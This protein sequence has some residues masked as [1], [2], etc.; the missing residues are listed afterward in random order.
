MKPQKSIKNS[1]SGTGRLINAWASAEEE[2]DPAEGLERMRGLFERFESRP[3]RTAELWPDFQRSLLSEPFLALLTPPDVNRLRDIGELAAR[4]EGTTLPDV[5]LPLA[6]TLRG[7]GAPG[8]APQAVSLFTRLYQSGGLT[9]QA[10]ADV[11]AE[12]AHLGA[13]GEDQLA[14][15]ADLLRTNPQIPQAVYDHL[16]ML[17]AAGF[18]APAD[19]LAKAGVLARALA[20]LPTAVPGGARALGFCELL[21][22]DNAAGAVPYFEAACRADPRD[23]EALR[24][25]IAAHLMAGSP[26]AAV[27]AAE[28]NPRTLGERGAQLADLSRM[29]L[30]LD[31][32]DA[33]AAGTPAPLDAERIAA[34]GEGP[35]TGPWQ[36]YALGRAQL[37]QGRAT[38][39]RDLLV[40][41]A[42]RMPVRA[43]IAYHAAW[44]QLLCGETAPAA[45][46]CRALLGVDW[47]LGGPLVDAD[48]DTPLDEAER[49]SFTDAGEL[50]DV[51]AA[52]LRLAEGRRPPRLPEWEE[53]PTAGATLPQLL[54]TLR[55]LL[56]VAAARRQD[57]VLAR[58]LRLPLFAR[59]PLAEQWL[60]YGLLALPT[61]PDDGRQRLENAYGMGRR[62][63]R[64]ALAGQELAQGDPAKVAALLD[65]LTGRRAELL[66]ARAEIRLGDTAAATERLVPLAAK[67]SPRARYELGLI[68]FLAA[69]VAWAEGR[70]D[71]AVRLA[72]PAAA[73]FTDAVV[74]GVDALPPVPGGARG[75]GQAARLLAERAQ[76]P[77]TGRA[78][79]RPVR[80]RE[81]VGWLLGLAQL[82]AEPAD[83]EPVLAETMVDWALGHPGADGEPAVRALGAALA[84]G[85]AVAP[86]DEVRAEL[87]AQLERLTERRPLP[88]LTRLRGR[89]AHLAGLLAGS[90]EPGAEA[91]SD[92]LLALAAAAP[93]LAR[94]DREGAARL[95]TAPA[96]QGAEAGAPAP[97]AAQAAG[98]T[99]LA[100]AAVGVPA[101]AGVPAAEQL[102]GPGPDGWGDGREARIAR[103]VGHALAGTPDQGDPPDDGIAALTA[104]LLV[105]RAAGLAAKD[106][107][108][109]AS[110]LTEALAGHNLT[111][112]ISL[113]TALPALCARVARAK[114][115]DPRTTA[116][117][118]AIQRVAKAHERADRSDRDS[119]PD[120]DEGAMALTLARC[121]TAVGDHKNAERMWR[122][123]LKAAPAGAAPAAA[124]ATEFAA[125]LCHRATVAYTEDDPEGARLRLRKALRYVPGDHPA[126]Q[127]VADLERDDH[128]DALLTHLL[129][130]SVPGPIERTGRFS[131]LEEALSR[132]TALW[133][134]LV[135]DDPTVTTRRLTEFVTEH[136]LDVPVLHSL[137]V[138]YREDVRSR[139]ARSAGTG[140]D[141]V[142]ATALWTL[143]LASPTFWNAYGDRVGD[144]EERAALRAELTGELLEAHR[145]QG[146]RALVEGDRKGARLHLG[147]LTA[148]RDGISTTRALLKDG[149]FAQAWTD[150]GAHRPTADIIEALEA[151]MNTPGANAELFRPASARAKELIDAWTVEVV[152]SARERVEDPA[153]VAKLPN[154]IDKDYESGI[155]ALEQAVLCGFQPPRL[156]L[157]ILEWHNGWQNC[158]YQMDE[159]DRMRKVVDGA[160]PYAA[161]LAD[162]CE[163]GRGHLRENQMLGQH[164]VDRGFL[165][166]TKDALDYFEEALK[167]DP[168]NSN[169]PSLL[170]RRRESVLFDKVYA[171]NKARRYD[172]ALRALDDVPRSSATEKS[173]DRLRA[174]ILMNK[175]TKELNDFDFK[176]A[177]QHMR[178]ALHLASTGAAAADTQHYA[179]AEEALRSVATGLNNRGVALADKAMDTYGS[180]AR[181][182][183]RLA[184]ELNTALSMLMDAQRIDPGNQTARNNADSV[185]DL[186]RRLGL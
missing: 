163:P 117:A 47:A 25:L 176:A 123:A 7:R 186:M 143:M 87:F 35:D 40:P 15:Y 115:R 110:A 1:L 133:E 86:D 73:R 32:P 88:E 41:L 168:S 175:G 42:E 11:A 17:L 102:G 166:T 169:A 138:L 100:T 63:A 51:A 128:M 132:R 68:G 126:V 12:L 54:E 114:R 84:R 14:L 8:D 180:Y 136:S 46:R 162:Q 157:T 170:D 156:L 83:A 37:L 124:A 104:P 72:E 64:L 31:S 158:L 53:L 95:L 161:L 139:L 171:E 118:A 5:W 98:G 23:G 131:A 4:E 38:E 33:T 13:D 27:T 75:L 71:E 184:T 172:S 167:W 182:S 19:R 154:G 185:R 92:P 178:Q 10:A 145:A 160:V 174:V 9:A 90:R 61:Y 52:R 173:I 127:M 101:P 18:E 66:R 81:D 56:A 69:V 22:A 89:A 44:A 91:A 80:H 50:R 96:E 82:Q 152:E 144:D 65:G 3:A 74:T 36:R 177:E 111:G 94:G 153:A 21:L 141:L 67:G 109:A 76:R 59:L 28:S 142:T 159:R 6:R 183:P 150:T 149:P 106:P 39:A 48:P 45:A 181:S 105:A 179:D 148:V 24:A 58:L 107:G 164:W 147:C 108:A 134:A 112:L 125:Y 113:E 34:L 120:A 155:A 121:A 49:A 60:W 99:A 137:A 85:C 55:A 57:A 122:R 151:L 70:R 29:L 79:W 77:G 135:G 30:W 26:A 2:S 146:A 129:P 43:D 97:A 119:A 20:D 140:A 103:F 16:A 93:A 165:D 78:P 130:D 62:Q 116:L